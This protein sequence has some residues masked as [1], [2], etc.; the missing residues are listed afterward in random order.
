MFNTNR[1]VLSF[2]LLLA[3]FSGYAVKAQGYVS[4]FKNDNGTIRLKSPG[5]IKM[6]EEQLRA[7]KNY[8]PPKKEYD[9]PKSGLNSLGEVWVDG[10]CRY[11]PPYSSAA[12]RYNRDVSEWDY[13]RATYPDKMIVYADDFKG[14][15]TIPWSANAK[16][17]K[18]GFA[19][20]LLERIRQTTGDGISFTMYDSLIH[21]S[22]FFYADADGY[23]SGRDYE[24]SKS[25]S[26]WIK[27]ISGPDKMSLRLHAEYPFSNGKDYTTFDIN[28]N[29]QFTIKRF[30]DNCKSPMYKEVESGKSKAWIEG[31]WNELTVKKDEFNTV[32]VFINQ[33]EL[34]RYQLS[35]LP[36]TARFA[37]FYLEMPDDWQKKNLMY[38]IK[39]I[40]VISYPKVN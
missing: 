15:G 12:S 13:C 3:V 6:E 40:A 23:K 36:I 9:K 14:G 34:C 25:V 19:D 28:D 30:C 2:C 18:S 31:G 24:F 7:S 22:A 5:E 17:G 1:T 21:A 26:I 27:R 33:T 39:Q 38:N 8:E 37:T 10:Y 16:R 20:S 32:T 11:R 4:I 35:G 29:G